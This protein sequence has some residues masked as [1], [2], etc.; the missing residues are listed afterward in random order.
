M[1]LSSLILEWLFQR[2]M[3]I[4]PNFYSLVKQME[5]LILLL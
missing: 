1:N 3:I 5:F 2:L 4:C